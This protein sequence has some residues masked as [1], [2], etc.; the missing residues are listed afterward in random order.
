M[1]SSRLV[2]GGSR[3]RLAVGVWSLLL[4]T[5]L[6][7]TA[8]VSL[9]VATGL[10]VVISIASGLALLLVDEPQGVTST[11]PLLLPQVAAAIALVIPLVWSIRLSPQDSPTARVLLALV[12]LAGPGFAALIR[13]A[14]SSSSRRQPFSSPPMPILDP[15]PQFDLKLAP[16]LAVDSTR[17]E[18]DPEADFND[19]AETIAVATPQLAASAEPFS[20]DVT[21]WLTRSRTGEEDQISGGVRVEFAPGERDVIVHL[22]FC[23]PFPSIPEILTEDLDG[24][25]LEIR[26]AAV[27]PFGAR[28]TVRKSPGRSAREGGSSSYS[29][30]VGFT[31]IARSIRRAA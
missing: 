24:A 21:Q 14:G 15:A 8:G 4:I 27:F 17:E 1:D 30:C 12:S 16:E 25:G 31:A 10:L 2:S 7:S 28:L 22:S 13:S 11:R 29:C 6:L 26:V 5:L 20:Q 23:P 3:R 18:E 19:V 9:T